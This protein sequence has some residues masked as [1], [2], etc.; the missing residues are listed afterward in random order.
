LQQEVVEVVASSF[1]FGDGTKHNSDGGEGLQ[2]NS[3][4]FAANFGEVDRFVFVFFDS[5]YSASRKV[6]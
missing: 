3:L 5:V 6:V 2:V 4:R 1:L